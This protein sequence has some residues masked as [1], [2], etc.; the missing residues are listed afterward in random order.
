M[1]VFMTDSAENRG[2]FKNHVVR[3][4]ATKV[5]KYGQSICIVFS[6]VPTFFYYYRLTSHSTNIP[7][8]PILHI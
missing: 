7:Y 8:D 6:A 5:V 1:T 2:V 3:Q 4:R